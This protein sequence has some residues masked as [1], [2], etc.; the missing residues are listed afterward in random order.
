MIL[1]FHWK[2]KL[3][4]QKGILCSICQESQSIL[5]KYIESQG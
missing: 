3:Y 2:R 5:E 1:K 4:N